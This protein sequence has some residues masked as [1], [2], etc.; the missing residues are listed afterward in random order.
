MS[1]LDLDA[2]EDSLAS[3]IVQLIEET[4]FQY[5][6]KR[7]RAGN[8]S[9]GWAEKA[10]AY[11]WGSSDN[12]FAD[13]EILE[14]IQRDLEQGCHELVSSGRLSTPV[15]KTV[16]DA[17]TRLF[18]WGGVTRGKDHNPPNLAS[19]I[20]VMKTAYYCSDSFDAPL[21]SAWTKLAAFCTASNPP[22]SDRFPQVIFDSRVSIAILQAIDK[23]AEQDSRYIPMRLAY[24]SR[25]LG[26]VPGRGGNRPMWIENLRAN[27]WKSG[28]RNWSAQ[29]IASK[30]VCKIVTTLNSTDF[31]DRMPNKLGG[32]SLW[33][34][35]G[36]EKVLFMQG[37]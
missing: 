22:K 17:A 2:L 12:S 28:Y 27:G 5:I 13:E 23:A 24:Q 36:V 10:L 3:V 37:Y 11:R 18:R 14:S 25:G 7:G 30:L 4:S 21:D 34:T 29:F 15:S 20:A 9:K 32:Q 31:V 35:R 8:V 19:I 33:N 1:A 16:C 26:Y 6:P